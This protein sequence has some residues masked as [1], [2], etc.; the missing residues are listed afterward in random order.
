MHHQLLHEDN[1]GD[2]GVV[3]Q[4]LGVTTGLLRA[5]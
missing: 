3:W 4:D 1:A 5:T 2:D